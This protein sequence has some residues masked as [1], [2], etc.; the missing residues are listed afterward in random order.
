MIKNHKLLIFTISIL[1]SF[2]LKAQDNINWILGYFMIEIRSFDTIKRKSLWIYI[3]H[4]V[5]GVKEWI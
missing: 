5:V 4:G 1:Y 3:L 2:N